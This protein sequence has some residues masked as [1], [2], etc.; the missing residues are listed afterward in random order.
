M[1]EKQLK[2][3]HYNYS[4]PS[5]TVVGICVKLTEWASLIGHKALVKDH[6][7]EPITLNEIE[8]IN[9]YCDTSLDHN[10]PQ[11]LYTQGKLYQ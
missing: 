7:C 10:H 8:I 3:R 11:H 9:T 1:N 2:T 5:A 6:K 4:I